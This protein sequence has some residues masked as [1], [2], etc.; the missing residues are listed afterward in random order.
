MDDDARAGGG[1]NETNKGKYKEKGRKEKE[2]AGG[3]QQRAERIS[4]QA[5]D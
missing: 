3:R 2:S 1:K 5:I 4:E